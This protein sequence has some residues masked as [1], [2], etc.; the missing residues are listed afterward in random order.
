MLFSLGF[1]MGNL[2]RAYLSLCRVS[3]VSYWKSSRDGT[4]GSHYGR[5]QT[6]IEACRRIRSALAF[7]GDGEC[8]D[9]DLDMRSNIG[10]RGNGKGGHN[11]L[12]GFVGFAKSVSGID[13]QGEFS[14]LEQA[15]SERGGHAKGGERTEHVK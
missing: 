12:G 15:I 10:R 7:G 1:A 4:Y 8:L 13:C 6:S 9:L 11:R 14:V 2:S 5:H 3:G